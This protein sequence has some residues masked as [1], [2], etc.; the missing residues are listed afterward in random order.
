[1]FTNKFSKVKFLATRGHI[2]LNK[3][4]NI[5]NYL[6]CNGKEKLMESKTKS[7]KK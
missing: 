7:I 3:N 6:D 1:M 5:K 4:R 2:C